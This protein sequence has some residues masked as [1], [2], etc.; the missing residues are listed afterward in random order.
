MSVIGSIKHEADLQTA[1]GK[2]GVGDVL[3]DLFSYGTT[4]LDRLAYQKALD[5]IAASEN[6]GANFNLKVL[7]QYFDKGVELLADNELHPALPP[8][9]FEVVR[10]Q[11]AQFTAGKLHSPE[12][13]THRALD[14]ALL[15][16]RRPRPARGHP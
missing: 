10:G 7:K 16:E 13:K 11:T 3:S 1:P 6:G 14:V 2:D 12:Y 9:A 8:D 5:D 4:T 15:P